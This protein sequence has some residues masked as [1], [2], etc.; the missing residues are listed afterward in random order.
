M[1]GRIDLELESRGTIFQGR[2]EKTILSKKKEDSQQA[3]REALQ[4]Q[5]DEK[6]KKKEEEKQRERQFQLAD[7]H[8]IKQELRNL[9]DQ[10]Q[11]IGLGRKTTYGN[12]HQFSIVGSGVAANEEVKL[13]EIEGNNN[14]I[15]SPNH[16]QPQQAQ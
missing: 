8:R 12:H 4:R 6:N 3:I 16:V 2:D 11:P 7:D 5:I 10:S 15:R 13:P 9:E 14:L 1:E